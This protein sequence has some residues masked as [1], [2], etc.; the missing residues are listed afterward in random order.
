MS[1]TKQEVRLK[2]M[3]AYVRDVGRGVGR[4]DYGACLIIHLF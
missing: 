2:V 1:S 4:I 3:E